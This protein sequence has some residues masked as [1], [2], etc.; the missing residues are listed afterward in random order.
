MLPSQV[1]LQRSVPAELTQTLTI[2]DVST[3]AQWMVRLRGGATSL[4]QDARRLATTV[5]RH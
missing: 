5:F 1:R 4:P 3:I 2:F